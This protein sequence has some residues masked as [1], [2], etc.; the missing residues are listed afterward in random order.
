MND[1]AENMESF[2]GSSKKIIKAMASM[3]AAD[4]IMDGQIDTIPALISA[5]S[6]EALTAGS[7]ASSATLIVPAVIGVAFGIH[8]IL[9]R[10][11][12]IDKARL[13]YICTSI[14]SISENHYQSYLN[15][16][17]DLND[18]LR[19]SLE[20]RL[21]SIYGIDDNVGYKHALLRA[22]T[23]LERARIDMIEVMDNHHVLA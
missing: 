21:S 6:G 1:I 17:N 5:V 9:E 11:S 12:E 3:L 7:L 2:A 10:I 4:V 13:G 15:H 19:D 14:E 22:T 20:A 18:L 8:S 23:N 16:F